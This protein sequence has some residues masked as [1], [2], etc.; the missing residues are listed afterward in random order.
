MCFSWTAHLMLCQSWGSRPQGRLKMCWATE[1]CKI[2][3]IMV[4]D[5]SHVK[6]TWKLPHP[7]WKQCVKGVVLVPDSWC[8][9]FAHMSRNTRLF[10]PRTF[11]RLQVIVPSHPYSRLPSHLPLKPA[12][13]RVGMTQ[14]AMPCKNGW[15]TA[16][17]NYC[18]LCCADC[19]TGE[20]CSSDSGSFKS[21][22]EPERHSDSSPH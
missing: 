9:C 17:G 5:P 13:A 11:L 21:P 19:C 12:P 16:M 6:E 14:G 10:F 4:G 22:P 8:P 20:Q 15:S 7:Q 18:T 2:V 1:M 3:Y